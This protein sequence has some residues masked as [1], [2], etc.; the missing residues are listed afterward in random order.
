M[1]EKGQY[2]QRNGGRLINFDKV[3]TR[4]CLKRD[5]RF[6]IHG[7]QGRVKGPFPLVQGSCSDWLS[8]NRVPNGLISRSREK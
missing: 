6:E 3:E 8:P 5:R 1:T 2:S 4:N 7:R